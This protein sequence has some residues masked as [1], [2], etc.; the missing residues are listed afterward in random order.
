[1][2]ITREIWKSSRH[3]LVARKTTS[4]YLIPTKFRHFE[5]PVS[6]G[7]FHLPILAHEWYKGLPSQAPENLD[8]LRSGRL[9]QPLWRH[10]ITPPSYSLSSRS[11]HQFPSLWEKKA[12]NC[13]L[14]LHFK[15]YTYRQGN[16]HE[17]VECIFAMECGILDGKR[18]KNDY[19]QAN[20]KAREMMWKERTH[21]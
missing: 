16:P 18:E 17:S 2:K 8:Q 4:H 20:T 11:P 15:I 12:H 7:C 10:G 6:N 5:P 14:W 3:H 1:M 9:R 21:K 13:E 19:V